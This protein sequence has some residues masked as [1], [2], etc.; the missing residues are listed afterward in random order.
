MV[1][2]NDTQHIVKGRIITFSP[3][4]KDRQTSTSWDNKGIKFLKMMKYLK[5]FLMHSCL[6]V[7]KLEKPAFSKKK[8]YLMHLPIWKI[9][10]Q[11]R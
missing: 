5:E 10:S 1:I 2:F 8:S 6:S 4:T 7:L 9:S 3:R 11:N